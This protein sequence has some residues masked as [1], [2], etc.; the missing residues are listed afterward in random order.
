LQC[1]ML[2]ASSLDDL[3]R[4]LQQSTTRSCQLLLF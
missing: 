2:A 1:F 4:L 3:R